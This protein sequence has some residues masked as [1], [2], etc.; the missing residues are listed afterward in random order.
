M[1]N[2]NH[3]MEW[4]PGIDGIKTGYINASG[5]NLAASAVRDGHRLIGVIMGGLSARSRDQQ[6]AGLLDLAFA[7]LGSG[8]AASRPVMAVVPTTPAV[9]AAPQVAA[10]APRTAPP[11]SVAPAAPALRTTAGT[12]TGFAINNTGA[13]VTNYH[14]VKGCSSICDPA[15]KIDPCRGVIGVQL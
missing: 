3:L 10:V 13:F 6:M 15:W 5:F 11:A 1:R 7:D 12:G 2:H 8:A 14:V 9:A 4:Y